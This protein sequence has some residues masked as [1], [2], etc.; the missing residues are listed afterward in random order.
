MNMEKVA[1]GV[2]IALMALGGLL[3]LSMGVK[4]TWFSPETEYIN[5]MDYTHVEGLV[6]CQERPVVR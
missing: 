2:I 1:V 6:I 4:S 5:C 3:A